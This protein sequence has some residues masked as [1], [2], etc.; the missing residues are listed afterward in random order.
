MESI[1]RKKRLKFLESLTKEEF[2]VRKWL[3]IPP[4]FRAVNTEDRTMG[5][6]IN[7]LYTELISRTNSMDI[8]AGFGMFG[9]QSK[10]RIQQLL[11]EIYLETIRPYQR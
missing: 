8:G 10:Y 5:D 9:A 11:L 2:F 4:F 7:K 6:N 3:V 1:D